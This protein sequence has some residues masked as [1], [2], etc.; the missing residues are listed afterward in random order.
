MSTPTPPHPHHHPP[1]APAAE[2]SRRLL[3]AGAA[4]STALLAG[5]AGWHWWQTQRPA[6]VLGS[7]EGIPDFWDK[8]FPQPNEGAPAVALRQF[9]HQPLIVNFWATWCPPCVAELPILNRF[10]LQQQSKGWQMLGIAVDKPQAV[11]QFLAR[12]PLGFSIG[13][14]STEGRNLARDLG[15]LGGGLPFTVLLDASGQV[16]Q[17]KIGQI[18]P[19]LLQDWTAL[20]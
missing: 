8:T 14:A 9:Q 20:H 7:P 6:S 13:L 19:Q 2:P 4:A 3:L 1:A 16:R 12:Q 10:F 15:N 11:R 17:R 18:T 5:A